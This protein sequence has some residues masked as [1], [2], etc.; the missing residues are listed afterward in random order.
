MS[1]HQT[2]E[3]TDLP[4]ATISRWLREQTGVPRAESVVAFARALGQNPVEALVAAGY[5]TVDEA[6][7]ATVVRTPLRDY[8]VGELLDELRRRTAA[9]D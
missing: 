1:Q 4:Q 8:A 6:G 5:L 9:D 7:A 3:L 2:A